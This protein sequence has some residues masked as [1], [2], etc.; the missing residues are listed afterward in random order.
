MTGLVVGL[1]LGGSGC[2][3]V[4]ADVAG[5]RLGYGYGGPANPCSTRPDLAAAAMGDALAGALTGTTRATVRAGVA[6]MAGS[7]ALSEPGMRRTFEAVWSGAGLRCPMQLRPDCDVAFA[8]GTPSPSGALLVAGT[9]SMAAGIEG[10]RLVARTGGHGWLLGDEGSGFWL[11][12]EVVR[13]ALGELQQ[14]SPTAGLLDE[15]LDEV[16]AGLPRDLDPLVTLDAATA[17]VYRQPPIR[18]ARYA[19]MVCAAATRGDPVAEALVARAA[20]LLA[21]AVLPLCRPD[22]PVVLAG[23]LLTVSVVGHRVRDTLA[24]AGVAGVHTAGD[25]A[26]AAAWLAALSTGIPHPADVHARLVGP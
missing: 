21:G 20:A 25:S 22:L 2:R 1:D 18:L 8:A 14:R 6:G 17:A 16:L 7:A 3:A 4:L 19:P 15:V 9:G 24:G 26:A 23:T 11:G 13:A 5:R 10:R 12:R